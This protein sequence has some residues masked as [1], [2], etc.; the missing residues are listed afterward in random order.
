M[1]YPNQFSASHLWSHRRSTSSRPPHG[2]TVVAVPPKPINTI[3]SVGSL[4]AHLRR[5]QSTWVIPAHLERWVVTKDSVAWR[6]SEAPTTNPAR[7]PNENAINCNLLK[8]HSCAHHLAAEESPGETTPLE[9]KMIKKATTACALFGC[10]KEVAPQISGNF[11]CFSS[12]I[13]TLFRTQAWRGVVV[14]LYILYLGIWRC[15]QKQFFRNLA[16]LNMQVKHEKQHV[17]LTQT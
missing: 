6:I 14:Q 15:H 2:D 9:I 8:W 7:T 16:T 12:L 5:S 10:A 11:A 1:L 3:R 4:A 13:I 17:Y